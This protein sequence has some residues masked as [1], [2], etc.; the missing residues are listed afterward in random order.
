MTVGPIDPL[1]PD[2]PDHPDFLRLSEAIIYL[3][4][5]ADGDRDIE[6]IVGEFIDLPSLIYMADQRILRTGLQGG[7]AIRARL[8]ALYVDAFSL[9]YRTAKEEK[10]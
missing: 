6:D 5:E 10:Q 7:N 2:R 3:D 8:L 9:G 4:G 1:F